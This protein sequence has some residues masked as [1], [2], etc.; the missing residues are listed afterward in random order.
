MM[1]ADDKAGIM[2]KCDR[3]GEITRVIR[4]DLKITEGPSTASTLFA[5]VDVESREKAQ[6]F[7]EAAQQG[8]A[9]FGWELNVSCDGQV[10]GLSLTGGVTEDGIIVCWIAIPNR[11][12]QAV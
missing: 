4:D 5:L 9:T 3:T 7:I 1:D 11:L 2:L 10:T 6:T 8:R 12:K